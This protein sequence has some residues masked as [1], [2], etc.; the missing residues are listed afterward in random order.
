MTSARVLTIG[1]AALAGDDAEGRMVARAL[2][3][4]GVR[5]ASRQV[6]DEAEAALEPALAAALAAPGLVVVLDAPGGSG[7]E[8]VRRALARITGARLVLN[9]KLL[10]ILEEDFARRGQAMPRRLDRLAL[11]P[12]GAELWP[13]PGGAPGFTLET[14]DSVV[15]V[16]PLGSG[17]LEALVD[18]RLRPL[19]RRRVGGEVSLLRT[20]LTTGLAPA[21]AEERLGAW[22]G[23]EGPTHVSTAL[24]EGDVWVRLSARGVS[25]Q[26]AWE[27]FARKTGDNGATA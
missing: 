15:A 17:H 5:V 22:L 14:A 23:K 12:Q 20:L 1:A 13:A 27:R 6:V 24:V 11:L 25:R 4:E 3:E 8:I 16:L 2:L 10:A 7:G 19:V 26:A 9:D 21:D 18:E